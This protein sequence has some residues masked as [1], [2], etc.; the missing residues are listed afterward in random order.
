MGI[1][2]HL[3]QEGRNSTIAHGEQQQSMRRGRQ[4]REHINA[5]ENFLERGEISWS[6]FLGNKKT[7]G[8]LVRA[9]YA[10]LS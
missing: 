1:K 2:T 8:N 4:R 6:D 10:A 9:N 3:I 5:V 7:H